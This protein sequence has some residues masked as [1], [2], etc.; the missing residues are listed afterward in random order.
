MAIN[1]TEPKSH[2]FD[3]S[4][5]ADTL[6]LLESSLSILKISIISPS[7]DIKQKEMPVVP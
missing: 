4:S 2:L 1:L 7:P 3:N 6:P 5:I